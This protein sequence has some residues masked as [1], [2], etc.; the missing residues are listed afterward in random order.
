[1]KLF[2]ISAI[3]LI[4]GCSSSYQNDMTLIDIFQYRDYID[5]Y[6]DVEDEYINTLFNLER[7]PDDS[8]LLEKRVLLKDSLNVMRDKLHYLELKAQKTL[9]E[10][11]TMVKKKET[12]FKTLQDV[13]K[14]IK[15][16]LD[17]ELK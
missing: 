7:M 12:D 3:F 13:Y 10:W 16:D 1:M 15:G 4:I 11:D 17:R 5:E 14:Q 6:Q 2:W 8:E 9:A